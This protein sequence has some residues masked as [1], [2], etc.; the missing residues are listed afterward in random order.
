ML[1]RA[2]MTEVE[3]ARAITIEER[4]M[5]RQSMTQH[6][7]EAYSPIC[8][9]RARGY[10]AHLQT[11]TLPAYLGQWARGMT[12]Q[13]GKTQLWVHHNLLSWME[14]FFV[15]RYGEAVDQWPA[16]V[17]KQDLQRAR[18]WKSGKDVPS[19]VML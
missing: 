3:Q 14:A 13:T 15:V 17:T 11:M 6:Q 4:L 1:S 10:A 16:K 18:D 8:I 2:D 12:E 9:A 19:V 7:A 5:A